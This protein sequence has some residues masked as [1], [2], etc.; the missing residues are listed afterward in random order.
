MKN[1]LKPLAVSLLLLSL[2]FSLFA[3]SFDDF[4]KQ[5]D[6]EY[7][8]FEKET[9]QK[10][11]DYVKQ[12]DGDFVKYLNTHFSV[13]QIEEMGLNNENM[14]PEEVP[15]FAE[16]T[17]K[18]EMIDFEI[19]PINR[20][21][22]STVFPNIKK[23]ED[24]AF[25]TKSLKVE[26]LGWPLIFKLD[27]AFWQL[28]EPEIKAASIASFWEET[29]K[30]NYNHFL[31]QVAQA[32]K[33]LN[34]NQWAYY[35]LLKKTSEQLYPQ[36]D[37]LQVLWQWMMLS[38][39][40]YKVKVGFS[41]E[42]MYLLMPSVYPIYELNFMRLAQEKY[43][44]INGQGE[45]IKTYEKDF[46]QAN[47]IMDHSLSKAFNTHANT[48]EKEF[49]FSYGAKDYKMNLEY[50][51][52]MINFYEDIPLS[53]ISL[54]LSSKVSN[55]TKRSIKK[56]F[57]PILEG[58]SEQESL[59]ILLAF[60]QQ[61]FEYKTDEQSFGK[62]RYFFADEL[63]H[64]PYA[65]CEDRSV[66]YA[67]LVKTLLHKDV[68]ALAFPGHMATAIQ[69]DKEIEG[70]FI[71]YQQQKYII[72]DPTFVGAP[73]GLLL[74]NSQGKKANLIAI[75]NPYAQQET[76]RLVW[77]KV[78]KSGGFKAGNL[79]D[80][81]F[82]GQGNI[83]VTGYF[84]GKADFEGVKLEGTGE[85]RDVFVAKYDAHLQVLWAQAAIGPDN[86]IAFSLALSK[87]DDLYVYGSFEKELDF[88]GTSISALNA[89]DV[90][91]AKYATDGQLQW[92]KKA[93][94]DKLD[95][96][97]DFIFSATF[98]PLGKKIGAK[99][100]SE[101]EDFDYY[102]VV[103]DKKQN[104]HLKG[105]FFATS[106]MASNDYVNYNFESD[107]SD[108]PKVLYE[109]DSKLK[110]KE[111]EATIAGVFAALKLLSANTIEINGG[112]IKTTFDNYNNNF[113]KYASSLYSNLAN[114]N[115]IKN[116][117]GIISIKIKDHQSIVLDKIKINDQAR[118][119]IVRYKSGNILV[120]VLSGIYV[121]AG[122]Y[123]LDMNSIKLFKETGDLLFDFDAD[124]SV[125]KLNLKSEILKK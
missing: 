3:Q 51:M 64:Y 41:P 56:S 103:V 84:V 67:F 32:A 27:E 21:Y 7:S 38:R 112:N 99:L 90:F 39:S 58:K 33:I 115:F 24:V 74:T 98:N 88:N 95:H 42:K 19:A 118:I 71:S 37:N 108:I 5:I 34:L 40:N 35:Q 106:G 75:P 116:E 6:K 59:S 82:D 1:I 65:D 78:T 86:D 8:A 25:A 12:I 16:E 101:A 31:F 80:L 69:I 62:E 20:S 96:S 89:P 45:S 49:S 30:T 2:N 9:Q 122:D 46:P 109:T 77:E 111:Y 55:I 125:K 57:A 121:G 13:Y 110:Q 117:K 18:G 53:H 60:V 105:S 114:M 54:Y 120:E 91:L 15:V 36:Q 28:K 50:D 107:L 26:Y 4:K 52:H 87:K 66:F 85:S 70:D 63:L 43:Y 47:I 104:I 23:E 48:Q 73:L 113:Q 11:N 123:W 76:T 72:A 102:G 119:R 14:K 81:V 93:G 100:Y 92:A 97:L 22:Q 79:N 44:I 94:I 83:Y 61:A 17:I 124:H 10:F 68:V 29:S